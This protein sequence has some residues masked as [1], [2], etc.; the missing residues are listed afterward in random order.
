MHGLLGAARGHQYV[1]LT[2][3]GQAGQVV[4]TT[5]CDR[6]QYAAVQSELG[7]VGAGGGDPLHV[8]DLSSSLQFNG[9]VRRSR[10][11]TMDSV[12]DLDKFDACSV[13]GRQRAWDGRLGWYMGVG[14][15]RVVRSRCA[16]SQT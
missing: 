4:F 13:Q 6:Q 16:S 1:G 12:H 8:C 10:I 15:L 2:R 11:G 9:Q 14:S 7:L 5:C 3:F